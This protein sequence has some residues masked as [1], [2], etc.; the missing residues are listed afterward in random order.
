MDE[1]KLYRKFKH[2]S[3]FAV[4]C[5]TIWIIQFARMWMRMDWRAF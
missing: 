2:Y 4:N 3:S 5:V 1:Q